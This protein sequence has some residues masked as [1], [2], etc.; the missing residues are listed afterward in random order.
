MKFII[1]FIYESLLYIVF[2]YYTAVGVRGINCS[3]VWFVS[4]VL[5]LLIYCFD[6]TT[7][8]GLIS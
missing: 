7:T 6:T 5:I 4:F 2:N 8:G 1:L 3:A